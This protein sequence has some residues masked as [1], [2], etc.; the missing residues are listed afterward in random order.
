SF[1]DS[2]RL[3]EGAAHVPQVRLRLAQ[4]LQKL[5]K[6]ARAKAELD[7][8]MEQ[9]SDKDVYA[10]A[11]WLMA[12]VH[13]DLG[14]LDEARA[15][16]RKLLSKWPRSALLPDARQLMGALNLKALRP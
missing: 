1:N 15:Q 11:T 7:Q 13:D 9:S 10:E 2:I 6:A 4:A 14:D 16:L 12:Q 3:D 8:V 5:G